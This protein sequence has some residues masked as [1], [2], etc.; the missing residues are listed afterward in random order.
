M[1]VTW[2]QR[3]DDLV[4]IKNDGLKEGGGWKKINP[5]H[6]MDKIDKDSFVNKL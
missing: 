6:T 2:K 1:K 5:E 3:R 4:Y